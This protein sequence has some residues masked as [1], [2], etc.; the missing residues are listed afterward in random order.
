MRKNIKWIGLG[1]FPVIVLIG[2]P[3]L[4]YDLDPFVRIP[5][6]CISKYHF[7]ETIIRNSTASKKFAQTVSKCSHTNTVEGLHNDVLENYAYPLGKIPPDEFY[8]YPLDPK[9]LWRVKLE[10]TSSF[11]ELFGKCSEPKK[12]VFAK[13]SIRR[14]LKNKKAGDGYFHYLILAKNSNGKFIKINE[15]FTTNGD[16]G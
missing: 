8:A 5:S 14:D 12:C 4:D 1:F 6:Y 2:L 3:W 16:K 15:S 10:E 11:S 13:F 7:Q 9:D